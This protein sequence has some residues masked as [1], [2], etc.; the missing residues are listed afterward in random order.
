MEKFYFTFGTS[1]RFPYCGGWVEV[2]A[3]DRSAAVK[4]FRA[5]YPD[6]HEGIVNCADIYTAAQFESSGMSSGNR[7]SFCHEILSYKE[8]L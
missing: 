8:E 5:K 7:G 1:E 3:P 4:T 2:L 6:V